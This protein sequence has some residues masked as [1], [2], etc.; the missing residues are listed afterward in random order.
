MKAPSD[1]SPDV[2][3]LKSGDLQAFFATLDSLTSPTE[4]L[5]AAFRRRKD[6]PAGL[7]EIKQADD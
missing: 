2:T 4:A 5:R 3:H 7:D 1:N 6:F